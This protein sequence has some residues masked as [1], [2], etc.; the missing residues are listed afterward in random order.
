MC[1]LILTSYIPDM[2]RNSCRFSCELSVILLD[3]TITLLCTYKFVNFPNITVP[4][5]LSAGLELF[6]A[7]WH[8]G[9]RRGGSGGR[10]GDEATK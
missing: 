9:M 2:H 10:K 3:L 1:K 5:N 6:R 7:Y 8:A 4:E